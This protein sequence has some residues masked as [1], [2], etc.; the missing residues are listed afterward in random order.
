MNI[1]ENA[2]CP[3]CTLLCDDVTYQI[4]GQRIRSD[5][6]CNLA[7]QWME[8]ANADDAESFGQS[9]EDVQA[10]ISHLVGRLKQS[11]LPLIAGLGALTLEGQQA[12]WKIADVAGAVL[13]KSI[14]QHSQG[15]LYALQR[16][17]RVTASLGEI[18][19]RGDL[20]IFWFCDPATT[21]PRMLE[22]LK[23]S[24]NKTVV[25]VDSTKTQ[26]GEAADHFI[27]LKENEAVEFLATVRRLLSGEGSNAV[28][29]S[30]NR[31]T[32]EA[33]RLVELVT[34]CRYGCF[35]YDDS[36][37]DAADAPVTLGHQKLV[38]RLNDHTR[39]VSIGLRTD[40]NGRSAENV[41]A[42]LCGY[43]MAVSQAKGIPE[44]CGN[45]WSASR[46]L[47]RR[48][49]DFLLLF[50][51]RNWKNELA[52]LSA[53]AKANLAALPKVVIHSGPRPDTAVLNN[54]RMLQVAVA[55]ASGSGD[56][57]RLDDVLLPL[58][59]LVDSKLPTDEQLLSRVFDGLR[60]G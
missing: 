41:I 18:A 33:I 55:G 38:R 21:H 54:A 44:H 37:T 2:I 43:P 11:K 19:N 60:A 56:F 13:D 20:L 27:S 4:E 46:L 9:V 3:G 14:G 8:W 10:G 35:V 57:C 15:S 22:R 25:V 48:Q 50:A 53:T 47:D 23:T 24:V 5:I 59:A 17:G 26:T 31:A 52:L 12:A 40:E 36:T 16:Q 7:Q 58:V 39:M 45:I 51:G 1:I 42:A 6:Q 49:C 30:A 34:K 28:S 29:P 32:N